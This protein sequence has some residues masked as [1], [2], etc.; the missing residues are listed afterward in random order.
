MVAR[1]AEE[2]IEVLVSEL[3]TLGK[4]QEAEIER[5]CLEEL[6]RWRA[7]PS[8][9]KESALRPLVTAGR[10]AIE[11]IKLT[12]ENQWI[13]LQR[14]G[15]KEHLALKYFNLDWEVLNAP[16]EEKLLERAKNQQLIENPAAVVAKAEK[17]LQSER[18]EDITVGLAILTGCRETELLKTGRFFF[19]SLYTVT[20]DGQLKRRDLQVKPYEKPV[21]VPAEAV[22]AAWRR[23]RGLIDCSDLAIEQVAPRYSGI[24]SERANYHFTGLIPQRTGKVNLYTHAFRAVYGRIAVHWFCPKTA[25]DLL[26]LATILGHFQATTERARMTFAAT[27]H[28][29]DYAIDGLKGIRLGESGVQILEAFQPKGDKE[30]STT[31]DQQ[32]LETAPAKTRGAFTTK[33]GTYNRGMQLAKE[34]G[35]TDEKTGAHERL[36]VDLLE[37]DAVAHQMYDLLLPLS[38]ALGTEGPISTLQ[39]LIAGYQTGGGGQN[40][41]LVELL[42]DVADE[43]DPIEYLRE[44]VQRDRKFQAAIAARHSNVDFTQV[45]MADLR[46]KYKTLEAAQERYRRAIDAVIAHNEQQTDPLHLWYIN[47]PLIKELVGGRLDFIQEYLDSRKEEIAAHHKRFDLTARQNRKPTSVAG[48]IVVE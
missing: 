13:N 44:L 10:K 11:R 14:G 25:D 34:R 31:P 27:I 47:A 3:T 17:L 48:E 1:W 39:A 45:P 26:Y 24:L 5:M 36:I 38:E 29:L 32:V 28:Y 19:K 4:D 23:L 37:H 40:P 33:P 8:I 42:R 43:P 41:R 21:L 15:K 30:M 9:K 18:W 7:R 46:K 35:F 22:I 20:F 2:R 6:E 12:P 16:S